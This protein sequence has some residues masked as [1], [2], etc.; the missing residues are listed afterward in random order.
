MYN[1]GHFTH[2]SDTPMRL[3]EPQFKMMRSQGNAGRPENSAKSALLIGN[4]ESIPKGVSGQP[5]FIPHSTE[6]P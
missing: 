4:Y 2:T 3:G 1:P 6:I 5:F